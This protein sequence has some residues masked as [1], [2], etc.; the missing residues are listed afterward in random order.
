MISTTILEQIVT[1]N[2]VTITLAETQ[3]DLN[4]QIIL[5]ALKAHDSA[6]SSWGSRID[7]LEKSVG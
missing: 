2:L 5:K 4:F 7:N 1:T 6:L 3:L